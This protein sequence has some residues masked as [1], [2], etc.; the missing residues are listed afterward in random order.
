MPDNY[1]LEEDPRKRLSQ[2]L[3]AVY[4]DRGVTALARACGVSRQ[5][6][7]DWPPDDEQ[8][9]DGH[10]ERACRVEID[11]AIRRLNLLNDIHDALVRRRK[12]VSRRATKAQFEKK[13]D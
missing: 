1:V 11:G 4:G 13:K 7:H 8:I 12:L 9:M 2:F 10:L 3:L 6:V 5:T